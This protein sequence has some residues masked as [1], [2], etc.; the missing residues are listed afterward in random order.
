MEA[1]IVGGVR[2]AVG[3]FDGSL[4][5]LNA[6]EI[7][8]LV[9]KELIART[10]IDPKEVNEVI[11][12]NVLQAGLGQNPA[13][14]A[15][16]KAGVPQNVPSFTVNKVCGSG[17]KTV[18][19]AANAIAS[20]ESDVIVAG[21][22]EHMSGA[23]YLLK[24][25]RS[26][27]RLGHGEATDSIISDALWDKFYDCHMGNTAENIAE[28]YGISRKEQD[29]FAAASQQKA[30]KAVKE[31][32]F[33][34]EIVPVRIKQPKGEDKIFDTDEHLRFGTTA[35]T[36]AKLKPAFKGDGTVTAGNASGINDGAA[37]VLV[38]SAEKMKAMNPSWAFKIVA[39]QSA[40]LDPAF[41][42]LGPINA[43]EALLART[44]CTVGN[45]DL[46]EVNEAFAAQSIQVH[47]AM[48]WDLDKVNVLGGA[49]ALGHPVGAS[50]TRIL[51][52][53]LY[54][55]LRKDVNLGLASLCIGGG[56]GIAML[57]ERVR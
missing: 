51:V 8:A 48:G 31:G 52:T 29:E 5:S 38:V 3:K 25:M 56:Q 34:D 35:E 47:R 12:G 4:A 57:V 42:G 14:Q 46:I 26:G 9:I 24:S 10:A 49:I 45:L 44:R 40:A 54:E 1:Y 20:G 15:S 43:S 2:T 13:R 39:A 19:L 30:E 7:G 55:M 32:R 28:K 17:L 21:G 36:L 11:M 23:P 16:I 41:M 27:Q 33:K 18:A 53:L 22:M 50:G 37:S 6:V